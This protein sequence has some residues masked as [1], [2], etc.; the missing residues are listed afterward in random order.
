MSRAD[1]ILSRLVRSSPSEPHGLEWPIGFRT[2]ISELSSPSIGALY[3]M[4]GWPLPSLPPLYEGVP[5]SASAVY[6]WLKSAEWF[7][8][9]YTIAG[10]CPVAKQAVKLPC[11]VAPVA[12]SG[13]SAVGI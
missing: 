1:V 3:T 6:Y 7:I 8:S 13:A 9:A 11:G 10:D 5:G 2:V 4:A 12:A